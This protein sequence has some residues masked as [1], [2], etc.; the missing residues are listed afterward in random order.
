MWSIAELL[1]VTCAG[2]F[3][4]PAMVGVNISAPMCLSVGDST[5]MEIP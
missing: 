5:I 1:V 2:P 3:A 4:N